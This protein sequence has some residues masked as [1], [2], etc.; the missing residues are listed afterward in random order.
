[1]GYIR[2]TCMRDDRVVRQF[3]PMQVFNGNDSGSEA[4][5]GS[6]AAVLNC[7]ICR[8][9]RNDYDSGH[10]R[11]SK[12]N[13]RDISMMFGHDRVDISKGESEASQ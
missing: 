1:M 12:G 4:V 7:C 8:H 13:S 3:P 9:Q 6:E 2:Y 5:V 11:A 10:R